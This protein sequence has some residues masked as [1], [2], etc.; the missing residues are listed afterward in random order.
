MKARIH[1]QQHRVRGMMFIDEKKLPAVIEIF[2]RGEYL[3][4]PP[5][6][7]PPTHAD[8]VAEEM[9]DLTNNPSRQDERI[10]RYGNGPSVSSGDVVQVDDRYFL[11][12][13]FGWK[14]ISVA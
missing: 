4:L 1:I 10:E 12:M 2:K 8:Q 11:C 5:I 14:E 6:E 3:S 13:S 9:F 7:V